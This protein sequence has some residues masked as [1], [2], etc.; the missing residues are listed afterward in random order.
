MLVGR[1][2]GGQAVPAWLYGGAL[3]HTQ[4]WVDLLALGP[5]IR[6]FSGGGHH[7]HEM[8]RPWHNLVQCSLLRLFGT[9][10]R[11]YGGSIRRQRPQ[12]LAQNIHR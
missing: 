2:W 11:R 6:P 4:L 5:E 12:L 3:L 8:P 1:G 9:S 10:S 7:I